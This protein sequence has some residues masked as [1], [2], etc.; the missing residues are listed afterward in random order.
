MFTSSIIDL[1]VAKFTSSNPSIKTVIG[2]LSF[3]ILI[4][5]SI[6]YSDDN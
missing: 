1:Q 3:P 4:Y 5:C 6:E 2:V